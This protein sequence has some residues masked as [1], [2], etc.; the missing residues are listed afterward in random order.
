MSQILSFV[1][2]NLYSTALCKARVMVLC[3]EMEISLASPIFVAAPIGPRSVTVLALMRG[4]GF[5]LPAICGGAGI[6]AH[7]APSFYETI[8][9][10]GGDCQP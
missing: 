7:H 4:S 10:K 8:C 1:S 6:R 3:G 9:R 2:I 5:V